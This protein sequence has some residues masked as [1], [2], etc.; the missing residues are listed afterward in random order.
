[1]ARSKL[2]EAMSA[3]LMQVLSTVAEKERRGKRGR[4]ISDSV[5]LVDLSSP[6]KRNDKCRPCYSIASLGFGTKPTACTQ[7]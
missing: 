4:V 7:L 2:S 6:A 3:M 1:M 5:S